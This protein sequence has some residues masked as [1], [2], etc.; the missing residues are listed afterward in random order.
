MR[1]KNP[2][3]DPRSE[4]RK[5]FQ[6]EQRHYSCIRHFD[7]LPQAEFFRQQLLSSEKDRPVRIWKVV[8]V[9]HVG[10]DR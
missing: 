10:S 3:N 1:G 8:N 9:W 6:G 4:C 2:D 5:Y 7:S